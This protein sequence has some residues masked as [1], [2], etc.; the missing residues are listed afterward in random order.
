M[1][2]VHEGKNAF[3][4]GLQ[5]RNFWFWVLRSF[6][7]PNLPQD[8]NGQSFPFKKLCKSFDFVLAP[9]G[10]RHFHCGAYGQK[11][12]FSGAQYTRV[13]HYIELAPLS[14]SEPHYVAN[15]ADSRKIGRKL[16]FFFLQISELYCSFF[17]ELVIRLHNE[18]TQKKFFRKKSVRISVYNFQKAQVF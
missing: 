8:L 2:T 9:G 7:L 15:Q 1:I 3:K 10:V 11:R 13:L 6:N 5:M 14:F 12:N 18:V 17:P 4:C 16:P